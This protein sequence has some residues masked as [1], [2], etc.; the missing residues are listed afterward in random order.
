MWST[1]PN[2][3]WRTENW[4]AAP[5]TWTDITGTLSDVQGV[6]VDQVNRYIYV[7]STDGLYKG[8]VDSDAPAWVSVYDPTSPPA[9]VGAWQTGWICTLD[10]YVC[11]VAK[12]DDACGGCDAGSG[13]PCM[14]VIAPDASVSVLYSQFGNARSGCCSFHGNASEW[15]YSTRWSMSAA[16]SMIRVAAECQP[17]GAPHGH[18]CS[19]NWGDAEYEMTSEGSPGAGAW[20]ANLIEMC[21]LDGTLIGTY[22]DP[23]VGNRIYA[24]VPGT[25][26]EWTDI[27]P[28]D[29]TNP[30][31]GF[32]RDATIPTAFFTDGAYV[33]STS[34]GVPAIIT[35]KSSL[36]GTPGILR[37]VSCYCGDAAQLF[38]AIDSGGGGDG[39]IL[40][41]RDGGLTWT[42]KTGALSASN[43]FYEI[44]PVWTE[45]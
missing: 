25:P 8:S 5:P 11:I 35:A 27:T 4:T 32:D 6:Q 3:L 45:A 21:D 19:A 36:A 7:M 37:H 33:Y 9:G 1:G 26:G 15:A 43:N 44:R 10:G 17:V 29:W 38:L 30:G 14:V 34:G 2:K 16:G 39:F 22:D 23:G 42:D 12:E 31:N 28:D 41:T 18:I 24:L 40:T 20:H 13:A